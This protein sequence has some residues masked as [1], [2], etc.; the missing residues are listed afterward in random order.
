MRRM[1]TLAL[2]AVFA[3]GGV[4]VSAQENPADSPRGTFDAEICKVDGLTPAE[5]DC[6]WK[7]L[8]DKLSASDLKLAMLLTASNSENAETAKKADQALDKSNASDK[9]RDALSSETSALVIEAED[10]CMQ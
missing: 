3:L 9:R 5:C 8:S 1:T 7:F 2:M 4:A 10:A 6:A